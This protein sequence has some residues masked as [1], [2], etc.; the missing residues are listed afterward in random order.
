[1]DA[2]STFLLKLVRIGIHLDAT[3]PPTPPDVDWEAV[4]KLAAEQKVTAIAWDGYARLY[5][6]GMVTVDMDR[7]LK[8]QWLALVYQ[9]F[10]L[11][12]PEYRAKIGHLASFFAQ[13]GIRMMVLKGYGLSL[14]YPVPMHRPCGDV[15]FWT[16]GEAERVDRVLADELGIEVKGSTEHH[17]TFHF[18]GQYFEHHHNFVSPHA[19]QSSAV[20]E[21]RLEALAS[22]GEEA[23][24]IDGQ[25]VF[26]PSP[27]FNALFLLRHAAAHFAGEQINIRQLLDWGLFVEKHR[28]RV[29]W[30]RLEDF[31]EKVGMTA[32]YRVLNGICVDYLGFSTSAFPA[33]RDASEQRVLEDVLCPEFSDPCPS[34]ILAQWLWRIRRWRHRTWKQK[35]VYPEP[36]MRTFLVRLMSHLKDP[37]S[38]KM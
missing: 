25:Q 38:L 10:E 26:L 12:Y 19:R 15:D 4:A 27:D 6:A 13:H 7:S 28:D 11:R 5:E 17:T 23:V 37:A 31:V 33:E 34:F 14:N 32:F 16:F 22:V 20:V 30:K 35:L 36:L 9:S 1:M 24:E 3:L 18:E 2:N 29:D 21:E 8:K